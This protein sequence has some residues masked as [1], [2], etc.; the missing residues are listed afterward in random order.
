MRRVAKRA[1][2]ALPLLAALLVF[3]ATANA[4]ASSS[5]RASG[6]GSF[7]ATGEV[8]SVKQ[9]GGDTIVT[10]TEVQLLTGT[11]T[12]V[13]RAVGVEIIHADG[14]FEATDSGT[15]TG[16]IA[17]RTGTLTISGA[18]SGVGN[19]ADGRLVGFRGTGGLEDLHL[20]GTFRTVLTGA[21]TADGTYSIQY[22]FDS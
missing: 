21:T 5:D 7:T 10:A 17:G 22:H 9:V 8:I 1:F 6:S 11:L 18:S 13:R 2:A 12:G 16:S 20:R 14:T 3:P 4:S 19:V 15:F